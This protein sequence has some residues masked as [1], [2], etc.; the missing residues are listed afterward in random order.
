MSGAPVRPRSRELEIVRV[1]FD[2]HLLERAVMLAEARWEG[3]GDMI[4]LAY[5]WPDL[6]PAQ[7]RE[8]LEQIGPEQL[9]QFRALAEVNPDLA[10]VIDTLDE[11]G[12]LSSSATD[13]GLSEAVAEAQAEPKP[14]AVADPVFHASDLEPW[15]PVEAEPVLEPDDVRDMLDIDL[16]ERGMSRESMEAFVSSEQ[17]RRSEAVTS[18]EEML[19]RV[20]ERLDSVATRVTSKPV[21]NTRTAPTLPAR[22]ATGT[23][24]Q[25]G[26]TAMVDDAGEHTFIPPPEHW[27]SRLNADRVVAIDTHASAP[28]DDQLVAIANE[29]GLGIAEF[30]AAPGSARD[31][32]GGLRRS[33]RSVTVDV[34]PLPTALSDPCLVVMRGRFTPKTIERLRAG[35]CDIPGTRATVRVNPDTRV[36][37]IPQA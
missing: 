14:E 13:P 34:G 28:T 24:L 23:A 2:K 19:R 21:G 36:L 16:P 37:V 9:A 26:A 8:R 31:L 22:M 3:S 20:R 1:L 18:G 5:L 15:D 32:F 29:L 27:I 25:P 30:V 7:R 35:M 11:R 33:G 17:A 4:R 10:R 12:V 6:A